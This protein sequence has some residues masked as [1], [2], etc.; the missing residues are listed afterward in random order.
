MDILTLE[1]CLQRDYDLISLTDIG[2]LLDSDRSIYNF[3]R[4]VNKEKFNNTERIVLYSSYHP[5]DLVLE[6]IAGATRE[7]DI[8]NYFVLICTPYQLADKLKVVSSKLSINDVPITVRQFDIEKTHPLSDKNLIDFDTFCPAPFNAAYIDIKNVALP[9]CKI[10]LTEFENDPGCDL[11]KNNLSTVSNSKSFSDLRQL[12]KDNVKSKACQECWS[13]ENGGGYSERKHQITV[14]DKNQWDPY[15][16]TVKRLQ[17]VPCITCNFKCRICDSDFSS[18]I[19]GEEIRFTSDTQHKEKLL[20]TLKKHTLIDVEFYKNIL[21][22]SLSDITYLQVLGGE[23]TLMKN[24]PELLDYIVAQGHNQHIDLVVNTNCSTWSEQLVN[25]IKQFK[26]VVVTLSVDSIGERFETERGGSWPGVLE[27]IDKWLLI[28]SPN[29]RL[30]ITTTISI[31]NVLY[32]DE[33][34]DFANSKNLDIGWNYVDDPWELCIDNLTTAAKELVY[35]R[36]HDHKDIELR[37]VAKRVASTAETSGS[38]FINLMDKYDLRRGTDFRASHM[39]IYTA[40][41]AK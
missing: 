19:A 1:K 29:I 39:E 27:T 6:K 41:L 31:Q 5:S 13:A 24:L 25:S 18:A 8:P 22:E 36:F 16:I 4:S 21:R 33:V 32:L 38:G 30:S 2:T 20:S 40:M 26:T 11:T 34:I 37:N 9:C 3:L 12:F 14:M 7:N 10:K 35:N 28:P 17:I 15:D 23:P